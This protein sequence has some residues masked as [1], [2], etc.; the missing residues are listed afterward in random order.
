VWYNL[1]ATLT[2]ERVRVNEENRDLFEGCTRE[3]LL[4]EVFE[5]I[6]FTD[7]G[8]V[9]PYNFNFARLMNAVKTD[10]LSDNEWDLLA[11]FM[12]FLNYALLTKPDKET[13]CRD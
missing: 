11:E 9:L 7:E 1:G 13:A 10:R 8:V 2:E 4:R 12:G 5:G 3:E 6:K